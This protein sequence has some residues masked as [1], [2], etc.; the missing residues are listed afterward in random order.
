VEARNEQ[1]WEIDMNNHKRQSRDFA[2]WAGKFAAILFTLVAT[3]CTLQGTTSQFGNLDRIVTITVS[4]L[5]WAIPVV[6]Q[7]DLCEAAA[8]PQHLLPLL[9]S[10]WPVL[11]FIAQ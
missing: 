3:L 5:R 9:A 1:T 2:A 8:L 11:C 10:V 7:T 4:V 6:T